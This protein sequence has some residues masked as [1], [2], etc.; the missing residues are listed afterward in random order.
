MTY[1]RTFNESPVFAIDF[2]TGLIT[3]L[4]T[5]T[6]TLGAVNKGQVDTQINIIDNAK[7]AKYNKT[8]RGTV[9]LQDKLTFDKRK[10][11]FSVQI[12]IS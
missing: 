4:N 12:L 2:N 7:Y 1:L 5:A 3:E 10:L 8:V 9:L 6:T 11:T